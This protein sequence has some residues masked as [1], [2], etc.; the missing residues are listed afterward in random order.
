MYGGVDNAHTAF[1]QPFGDAV[2]LSTWPS[3]STSI[4]DSEDMIPSGS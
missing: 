4:C 2:P 3:L 1:T